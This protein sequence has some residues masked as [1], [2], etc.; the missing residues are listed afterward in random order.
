M[1]VAVDEPPEETD[2]GLKPT[3]TPEGAPE[4][5]KEIDTDTPETNAVTTLAV[6][7]APCATLIEAGDIAIAKLSTTGDVTVRE[8]VVVCTLAPLAPVIVIGK[9]PVAADAATVRVAVEV[10]PTATDAGE[11]VTVTPAGAPEAA[12]VIEAA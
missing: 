3:V 11:S 6:P 5:L 7:A 10:L 2:A 1:T 8:M 4:A 9:V 12:K